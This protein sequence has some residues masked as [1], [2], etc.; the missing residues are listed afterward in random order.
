MYNIWQGISFLLKRRKRYAG[1]P[2]ERECQGKERCHATH[3]QSECFCC[4]GNGDMKRG[5]DGSEKWW[6]G[7]E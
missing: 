4:V 5:E 6:R 7:M 1:L 2:G 3:S